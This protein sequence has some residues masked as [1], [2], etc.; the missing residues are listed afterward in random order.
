MVDSTVIG[1]LFSADNFSFFGMGIVLASIKSKGKNSSP[2]TISTSI[3]SKGSGNIFSSRK[4]NRRAV[5]TCDKGLFPLRQTCFKGI[6][7]GRKLHARHH[8]MVL[9]IQA[10][11][12]IL[13]RPIRLPK[14]IKLGKNFRLVKWA[15]ALNDRDLFLV[16]RKILCHCYHQVVVTNFGKFGTFT[17]NLYWC[18]QS[19]LIGIV[20]ED[21]KLIWFII[22]YY[23][24][25]FF[26]LLFQMLKWSELMP[27]E[28]SI[29]IF[30]MVF[31]TLNNM[32]HFK[33]LSLD[34]WFMMENSLQFMAQNLLSVKKPRDSG[35]VNW[36]W[37]QLWDI[38]RPLRKEHSVK[39]PI[40]DCIPLLMQTNY[41]PGPKFRSL[42]KFLHPLTER[43]DPS[44]L[45]GEPFA[46]IASAFLAWFKVPLSSFV[47][48]IQLRPLRMFFP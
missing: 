46:L 42:W 40:N 34:A 15:I 5:V 32:S 26:N 22:R 8:K 10:I 2:C 47:F 14:G 18:K 44:Y 17:I 37:H 27:S 38:C 24:R 29:K 3:F 36:Y 13:S 45:F 25:K 21:I 31:L 33:F 23:Q 30:L 41:G 6:I 11:A 43:G 1:L 16:W 28:R 12:F 35:Q 19:K 48:P 20:D 9:E 7:H 4:V 39:V